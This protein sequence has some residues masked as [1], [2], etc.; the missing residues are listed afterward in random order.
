MKPKRKRTKAVRDAEAFVRRAQAI[1][2]LLAERGVVR[3]KGK[4]SSATLA[5]LLGTDSDDKVTR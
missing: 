5:L 4:S 3:G 2:R 1:K